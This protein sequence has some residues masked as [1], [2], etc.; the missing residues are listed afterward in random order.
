MEPLLPFVTF[1]IGL[2][3][4]AFMV[5]DC[6]W[7]ETH[8][9]PRA[10]KPI[11][12]KLTLLPGLFALA[13]GLGAVL[14]NSSV[15][16]DDIATVCRVAW[17]YYYLQIY[18]VNFNPKGFGGGTA[19]RYHAGRLLDQANFHES[20]KDLLPWFVRIV[21]IKYPPDSAWL[22]SCLLRIIF[23]AIMRLIIIVVR[24][25]ASDYDILFYSSGRPKVTEEILEWLGIFATLVGIS[26]FIPCNYVFYRIVTPERR[27]LLA[28]R[29]KAFLFFMPFQSLVQN[30]VFIILSLY[31]PPFVHIQKFII[32]IEM[33][34]LQYLC[35]RCYVPLFKWTIPP[36][37]LTVE[38]IQA[39]MN[40]GFLFSVP[41]ENMADALTGDDHTCYASVDIIGGVVTKIDCSDESIPTEQL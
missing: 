11:L 39:V 1:L 26:G 22:S 21:G 29:Q 7:I 33:V 23:F 35:H 37:V 31:L 10:F 32:A 30:I 15:F 34:L 4:F 41:V 25:I 3:T 24:Q 5:F 17:L 2:A 40:S 8:F 14:P 12:H 36:P 19:N 20:S 27:A 18:L 9:F 16:L 38:Q 28:M 6:I 13:N